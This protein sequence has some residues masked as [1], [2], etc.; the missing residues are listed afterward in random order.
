MLSI[1]LTEAG[2][3]Q[4]IITAFCYYLIGSIPDILTN[5]SPLR[6]FCTIF[7]GSCD[8]ALYRHSKD[9]KNKARI[10]SE[11]QLQQVGGAG[12]APQDSATGTPTLRADPS[13]HEISHP[14]AQAE[15]APPGL[16]KG[17]N[18]TLKDFSRR[19]NALPNLLMVA[20]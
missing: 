4:V 1:R 3:C 2:S 17:D 7:L 15:Y 13:Q 19:A 10:G 18:F 14:T 8:S 11:Q 16:G 6:L 9:I 12:F 5:R 20:I